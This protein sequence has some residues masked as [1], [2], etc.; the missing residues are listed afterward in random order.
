MIHF[1]NYWIKL[2]RLWYGIKI[3]SGY[4]LMKRK[5]AKKLILIVIWQLS[6]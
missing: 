1:L 2:L 4:F 6:R 5:R 3:L